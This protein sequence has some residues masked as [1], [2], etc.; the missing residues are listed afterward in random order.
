MMLLVNQ[1]FIFLCGFIIVAYWKTETSWQKWIFSVL[2]LLSL[3][4]LASGFTWKVIYP[5]SLIGLGYFRFIVK[6]E[7]TLS[8]QAVDSQSKQ[9]LVL[10]EDSQEPSQPIKQ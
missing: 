10:L 6:K 1:N 2:S 8:L 7:D 5:I 9:E 3:S 4:F